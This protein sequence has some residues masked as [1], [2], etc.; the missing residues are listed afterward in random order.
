M[1]MHKDG[2][3]FPTDGSVVQHTPIRQKTRRLADRIKNREFQSVL[4]R[5]LHDLRI[6]PDHT[7]AILQI[8][9][10][11]RFLNRS[12]ERRGLMP[13]VIRVLLKAR[14]LRYRRR[15]GLQVRQ[16]H[17]FGHGLAQAAL[18]CDIT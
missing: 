16:C 6:I 7:V 11:R 15:I 5:C 1:Q 8:G 9:G 18:I 10:G 13:G 4:A 14:H 17:A 12:A 2:T 3:V